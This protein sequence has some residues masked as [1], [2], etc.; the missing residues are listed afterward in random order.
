[1][2]KPYQVFIGCPFTKT[3]RKFY[4]RLK[5][6]IELETPLHLVIADTAAITSTN[7]LLEHIT[8]LIKDSI[9][10]IFDATGNNPN[11]SLEVGIAHAIPTDYIICLNTRKQKKQDDK[12]ED[13]MLKS[14]ISDLQGKNRIEYKTYDKLKGQILA[15]HFNQ[16][17]FMRRWN[18]Y[19]KAYLSYVPHAI[20][21]FEE[22]RSS[23][24]TV[25]PRVSALL[26]GTGIRT[27]DFIRSLTKARL[28]LVREGR[29]GG[30]YYP[31]R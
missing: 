11:V 28:L 17:D 24:R 26:A 9:T 12:I 15:R 19:K 6:E 10:C 20:K 7:Y 31:Q 4:D 25:S 2:S 8:N 23:T 22:V 5:A 14:I 16:L 30:Y 27:G 21:L 3:I 1:M 18:E 13:V 29:G